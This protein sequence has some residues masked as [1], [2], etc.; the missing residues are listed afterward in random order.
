MQSSECLQ[1]RVPAKHTSTRVFSASPI[2]SIV[3]EVE[4]KF[5]ESIAKGDL[6]I[7]HW[8]EFISATRQSARNKDI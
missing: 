2:C 4:A 7:K 5:K 6:D 8:A 3:C 1:G